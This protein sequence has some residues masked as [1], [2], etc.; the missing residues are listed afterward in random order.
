MGET[1]WTVN[2]NHESFDGEAIDVLEA[3][4]VL[5]YCEECAEKRDFS[6]IQVPPGE[7]AS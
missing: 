7:S 1:A 3:V 2:V 6:Q 4:C 5:I